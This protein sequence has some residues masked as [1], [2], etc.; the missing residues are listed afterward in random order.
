[1]GKKTKQ[2]CLKFRGITLNST[3]APEYV[4]TKRRKS[5]EGI[6]RVKDGLFQKSFF[7][8]TFVLAA[9]T[10]A[11][12]PFA[13]TVNRTQCSGARTAID[14]NR[15]RIVL[16]RYD[17]YTGAPPSRNARIAAVRAQGQF[18]VPRLHLDFKNRLI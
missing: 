3:I 4:V 8:H 17:V 1:M 2:K 9:A 10:I 16:P 15:R 11:H 13:A 14:N 12:F 7:F 18:S 6:R 5:M